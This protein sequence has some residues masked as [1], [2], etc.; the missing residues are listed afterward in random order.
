[1]FWVLQLEL[2][3]FTVSLHHRLSP[4]DV[5]LHHRLSPCDVSLHVRFPF[6]GSLR[7]R[8]GTVSDL[9]RCRVGT[10]SDFSVSDCTVSSTCDVTWGAARSSSLGAACP[11]TWG[12]ACPSS[13][14]ATRSTTW[15]AAHSSSFSVGSPRSHLQGGSLAHARRTNYERRVMEPP[16]VHNKVSCGFVS[17]ARYAVEKVLRV[18]C[19]RAP[20]RELTQFGAVFSVGVWGKGGALLCARARCACMRIGIIHAYM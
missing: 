12:A 3:L 7:C 16:Q 10:V 19:M 13:W 5:S 14:G 1:M 8:V 18:W 11:T 2:S 20:T 9:L 6:D 15:G 17:A 4:C